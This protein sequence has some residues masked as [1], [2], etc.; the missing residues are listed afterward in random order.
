MT[1]ATE[2]IVASG[3]K[4]LRDVKLITLAELAKV[5]VGADPD[6]LFGGYN[7]SRPKVWY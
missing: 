3:G 6:D 1:D 5:D 4:I 2:K 7:I